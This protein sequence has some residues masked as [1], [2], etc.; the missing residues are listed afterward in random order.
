MDKG[1]QDIIREISFSP[2]GKKIIFDRRNAGS[3]SMIHV[4]D[5]STGELSAY[6]SPEGEKWG[7]ARYSFDGKHIVFIVMPRI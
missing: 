5:L 6:Q 4:Y 3:A 7:D 2:D 1:K